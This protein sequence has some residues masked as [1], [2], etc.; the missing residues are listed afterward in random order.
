MHYGCCH[1]EEYAHHDH[2]CK[3]QN[4]WYWRVGVQKDIIGSYKDGHGVRIPQHGNSHSASFMVGNK[5]ND[6]EN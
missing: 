1:V 6:K 3:S 5:I 4:D 2:L